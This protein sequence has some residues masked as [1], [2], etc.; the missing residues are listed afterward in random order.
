[1]LGVAKDRRPELAVVAADALKD[2]GAVV[3]TMRKDMDLGVLPGKELSVHPYEVACVHLV[4]SRLELLE[5]C[6]R[7]LDSTGRTPEIGGSQARVKRTFNS[8]F[9]SRGLAFQT[10]AMTQHQRGG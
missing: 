6:S 9:Y 8:R 10:K 3:Q 2:A 7:R 4:V 5:H 1:M